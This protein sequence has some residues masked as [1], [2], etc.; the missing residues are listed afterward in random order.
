[1]IDKRFYI[2]KSPY[3]LT[4]IA[5]SIDATIVKPA[6]SQQ[7]FPENV[8]ISDIE[9]L[10][11]GSSGCL[12]FLSNA[13]YSKSLED[14]LSTACIV[15]QSF[16]G[17]APEGMWLLESENSYYSYSLALK[18]FYIPNLSQYGAQHGER[19]I[20]PSVTI[21]Q[22]AVIEDGAE[23]GENSHIGAGSFIGHGVK[24]GKN[25]QIASNVTISYSIIG[26]DVCILP[27]A[28][29][30]QDGF[31]FATYRTKHHKIFHIGRVIIGNDVEI[32]ANTTI[33]R[34]SLK[35]TII[36]DGVRIDNLVQI[37]HNV[38]IGKGTIIV[39]QVGI[40]GSSKIGNFCAL[41][42]QVGV[43]G[44][45]TVADKVQISGQA[46]IIQNVTESG[47]ILGG[48]PAVPI[49]DW[50]KQSIALRN[51]VKSRK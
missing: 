34:G 3:S 23:I 20:H 32:G 29:I 12:S 6:N 43:A 1:M 13:K 37:G 47:A 42:G 17:K 4:Q 41:G 10:D 8:M 45:I 36:E 2:N 18:L 15:D 16:Q 19:K 24:I 22:N 46:G 51:L 11:F 50:H 25:A 48:T 9:P 21:G 30:G 31:G 39:A 14:S 26:D 28:R 7:V 49:R 38:H 33:D 35:D 5:A 27:G 44:H 40:A